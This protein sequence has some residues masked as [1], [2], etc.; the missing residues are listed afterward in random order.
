MGPDRKAVHRRAGRQELR[1]PGSKGRFRRRSASVG[2]S[3]ETPLAKA[4]NLDD[5]DHS[6]LTFFHSSAVAPGPALS[7]RKSGHAKRAGPSHHYQCH[8]GFAPAPAGTREA[9]PSNYVPVHK[10]P[11]VSPIT[12]PAAAVNP[13]DYLP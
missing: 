2:G 5:F 11:L 9:R 10:N 8:Q 12:R 7:Q 1:S 4:Q 6:I 13:T 3:R